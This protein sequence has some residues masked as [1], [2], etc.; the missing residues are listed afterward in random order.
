MRE[1]QRNNENQYNREKAAAERDM[2]LNQGSTTKKEQHGPSA[3]MDQS[4][5]IN[6]DSQ[7]ML[8]EQV[9]NSTILG[10]GRS[11]GMKNHYPSTHHNPL[12]SVSGERNTHLFNH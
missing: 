2:Y 12:L 5:I 10:N 6:D 1:E 4:S 9:N 7:F 3:L 11:T 8:R